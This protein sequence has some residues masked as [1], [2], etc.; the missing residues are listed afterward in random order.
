MIAWNG[1]S[2]LW[3]PTLSPAQLSRLIRVVV[4]ALGAAATV[5]ALGVQ[6]V[7]ALWFF[8]TGTSWRSISTC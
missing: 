7:Q 6:S 5:M 4:V 1:V 8:T 3:R 2:R